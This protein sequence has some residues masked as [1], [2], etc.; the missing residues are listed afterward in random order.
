MPGD[1]DHGHDFK[2]VPITRNCPVEVQLV[3]LRAM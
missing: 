2:L 1:S 3:A